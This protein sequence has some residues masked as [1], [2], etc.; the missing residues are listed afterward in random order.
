MHAIQSRPDHVEPVAEPRTVS[1]SATCA[2]DL[3]EFNDTAYANKLLETNQGAY[4]EKSPF[5][6]QDGRVYIPK[7]YAGVIDEDFPD[8]EDD[9]IPGHIG[10]DLASF[11]VSRSEVTE[12]IRQKF[13]A[14]YWFDSWFQNQAWTIPAHMQ[15]LHAVRDEDYEPP[16]FVRLNSV[17]SK[18]TTPIP[19]TSASEG[20]QRLLQSKRCQDAIARAEEWSL[21][22]PQLV[23]RQWLD[24]E[25]YNEY[26]VF[27]FDNHITAIGS[28][29]DH[30]TG[31]SKAQII[32]R[33]DALL[34]EVLDDPDCGPPCDLPDFIMDVL[35]LDKETSLHPTDQSMVI[36]RDLVVEFNSWGAWANAG[37]GMFHW[38]EDERLLTRSVEAIAFE[39]VACRFVDAFDSDDVDDVNDA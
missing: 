11:S 16:K 4:I 18:E 10:L 15:E 39:G 27:V 17:S 22:A 36:A 9:S 2:S 26:R 29:D 23:V 13:I 28:N 34:D 3:L 33:C 32:Q 25:R 35:L 20:I 14:L 30:I 12:F 8:M 31:V 7:K 19:V 6:N 21:P 1:P 24:M 5:F 37:C 38:L